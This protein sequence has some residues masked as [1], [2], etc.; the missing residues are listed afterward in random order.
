M[1]FKEYTKWNLFLGQECICESVGQREI[2]AIPY[3]EIKASLWWDEIYNQHSYQKP[4]C[5]IINQGLYRYA[6]KVGG[7][8][9]EPS[10]SRVAILV[11]R[12]H[13]ISRNSGSSFSCISV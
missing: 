2:D 4:Y 7:V 10:E 13:A 12:R 9:A 11:C 6:G 3:P 1:I 8:Y 5:H